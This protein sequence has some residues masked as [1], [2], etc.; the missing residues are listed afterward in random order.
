LSA[1]RRANLLDMTVC[2]Y[3]FLLPYFIP[4]I[5]ASSASQSGVALGMPRISPWTAG[6]MNFYGWALFV[7]IAVAIV[8][9]CGRREDEKTRDDGA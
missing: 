4:T 7:T 2:T 5:L 8:T 3:P 1:Y 9:G 6:M